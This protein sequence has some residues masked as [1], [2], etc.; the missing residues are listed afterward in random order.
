M[1]AGMPRAAGCRRAAA[2][3]LPLPPPAHAARP[4]SRDTPHGAR[5]IIAVGRK[6]WWEGQCIKWR[7]SDWSH[8]KGVKAHMN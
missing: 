1:H 5:D 8:S 4:M 2:A 6:Q 3:A 7:E